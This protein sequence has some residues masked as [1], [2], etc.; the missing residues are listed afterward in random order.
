MTQLE[1]LFTEDKASF[2][3]DEAPKY[4]ALAVTE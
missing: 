4:Y 1:I 3:L 2:H